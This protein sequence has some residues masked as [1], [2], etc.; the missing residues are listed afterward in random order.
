MAE[1]SPRGLPVKQTLPLGRVRKIMAQ[2]MRV[3]IRPWPT[4]IAN[5]SLR[6]SS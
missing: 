1:T 3:G 2:T 6:I 4:R 5:A